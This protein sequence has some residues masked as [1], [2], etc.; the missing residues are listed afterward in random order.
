VS[1]QDTVAVGDP[2]YGPGDGVGLSQTL[3]TGAQLVSLPT[4]AGLLRT[5]INVADKAL[6][7]QEHALR[8]QAQRTPGGAAMQVV[9]RSTLTASQ[10][11][12]LDLLETV[13]ALLAGPVSAGVRGA[14]YHLIA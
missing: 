13:A 4:T 12:S 3:F 9:L 7:R 1:G 14:L 10:R 6:S 5:A 11:R 8:I 2:D